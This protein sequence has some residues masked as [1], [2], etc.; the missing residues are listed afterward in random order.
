MILAVE[1]QSELVNITSVKFSLYIK[2]IPVILIE[3]I[4]IVSISITFLKLSAMSQY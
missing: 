2:K 4:N 3:F 1:W